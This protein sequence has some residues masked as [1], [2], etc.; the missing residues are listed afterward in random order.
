MLIKYGFKAGATRAN[1]A[2]DIAKL[3][4]NVAVADLS[5]DCDK[6]A[7]QIITMR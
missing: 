4:S 3:I 1:M 6:T 5:A 7:T 2:A